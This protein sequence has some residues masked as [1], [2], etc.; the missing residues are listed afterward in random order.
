MTLFDRWLCLFLV[1]LLRLALA[2]LLALPLL[3]GR[4]IWGNGNAQAKNKKR[5][6]AT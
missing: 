2:G 1:S 3:L 6:R 4:V 5:S